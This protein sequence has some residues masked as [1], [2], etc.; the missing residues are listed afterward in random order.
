MEPDLVLFAKN[1]ECQRVQALQLLFGRTNHIK[2]QDYGYAQ[3]SREKK[4]ASYLP[5]RGP[6]QQMGMQADRA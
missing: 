6:R 4:R 1:S 5:F 3:C 2:R